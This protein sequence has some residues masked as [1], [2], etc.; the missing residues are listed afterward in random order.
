MSGSSWYD[1]YL[2]AAQ[3]TIGVFVPPVG[4]VQAGIDISS[5]AIPDQYN[6]LFQGDYNLTNLSTDSIDAGAA[7]LNRVKDAAQPS[8][9]SLTTV[10]LLGLG[11]IAVIAVA[12]RK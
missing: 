2:T 4:V 11:L 3:R 5:G 9:W 7:A 6:P 1:P 10:V 8:G 12:S